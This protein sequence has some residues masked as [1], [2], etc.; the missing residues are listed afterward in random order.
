MNKLYPEILLVRLTHK[1]RVIIRNS[2]K[3]QKVSEA[4]LV[5]RCIE[6]AAANAW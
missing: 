6:Y 3:R 2:A 1:Q 5:R 4:E